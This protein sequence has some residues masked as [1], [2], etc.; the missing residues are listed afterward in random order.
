MAAS[1]RAAEPAAVPAATSDLE[2]KL[3]EARR[4]HLTDSTRSRALAEEAL[5]TARERNDRKHEAVALIELAIALRRQNHN[6]TAV[7]HAR[8]ALA[9]VETL[10]D[11]PLLRRAV[12]ECG[13]TFWAF[14]DLPNALDHF[15]RALR[16][17]EE[18]GDI[19]GQSDAHAGLGAVSN[20][21]KDPAR[22]RE[23]MERALALAEK[24]GEGSRIALYA[25]NLGHSYFDAKDH[26]QARKLYDRALALFIQ[27]DQRT[28]AADAR[29][30]LARVDAAEGNLQRAEQTLRDLLPGRRRLRGRI[31][32]TSTLVQLANVLR[33]QGRHDEALTFLN[34]AAGHA[35]Q[36]A[37]ASKISVLDAL[38]ETQEARGDL[39][40]ALK[41]LRQRQEEADRQNGEAAQTRAA[42]MRE[43][44]AA[45]RRE[46]EITRLRTAEQTRATELR[47][48]EAE[49]RAQD[50]ELERARWQRYG[51]V[52]ALALGAVSIAAVVSRQRLKTRTS[53]RILEE[54]RAA[55]RVA[56]EADRIKTR[57]LGI[58]SHDIRAPMGNIIN[59]TSELRREATRGELHAERCDLIG[60]EAQRVISLVED[61]ITTAA[62]E[63]GK[64][65]LKLGAMDLGETIR[66]ALETLRHQAEAKRQ[67][68]EFP[69]PVPGAGRMVGDPA[70][71]HQVVSNLLSNA[72]KFSPP[73]E[74]I[75][76]Q[77][78][79]PESVVSLAVR[80]R[81]AGIAEQDIPKLFTPFERLATHPTA[82]ES[83]HGLGLSIA[84]DIVRRHGGQLRV[85]SRPGQGTTFTVELPAEPVA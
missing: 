74:T 9:I 10:D 12:K 20:D 23:H 41:A 56:E 8:H 22:G 35:A 57:F 55:Q 13:H 85:E 69:P 3:A 28:S 27:L 65:E 46:A 18:A 67:R 71:L 21:L 62:L 24:A 14:G 64:L 75:A 72:I 58:A 49:V 19:G 63:S 54:A 51:L 39:A 52:G 7:Q 77:L 11:R 16:L 15:Q 80:D 47:A 2:A 44:F 43:A 33:K 79:R 29:Q 59:L 36:L 1:T 50:A 38:V 37:P 34:E 82:G 42:E 5:A 78:T 4:L 53:Q 17:S 40:A 84:H 61:L 68:I 48:R 66:D 70:R 60:A 81:G 26:A 45:E 32:L 73:G 30:D 25:G 31:K 6:G 83:S 76:V